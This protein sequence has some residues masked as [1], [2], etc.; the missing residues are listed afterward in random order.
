MLLFFTFCVPLVLA[1]ARPHEESKSEQ[2]VWHPSQGDENF[3]VAQ[4]PNPDDTEKPKSLELAW[5]YNADEV[6]ALFRTMENIYGSETVLNSIR[7]MLTTKNHD[8]WLLFGLSRTSTFGGNDM[9]LLKHSCPSDTEYNE[10]LVGLNKDKFN[11]TVLDM[12][13]QACSNF[14]FVPVTVSGLGNPPGDLKPSKQ[15]PV[16]LNDK[17]TDTVTITRSKLKNIPH[18]QHLEDIWYEN[19]PVFR[20]DPRSQQENML[21]MLP[22]MAPSKRPDVIRKTQLMRKINPENCD[23]VRLDSPTVYVQWAFLVEDLNI[24]ASQFGNAFPADNLRMEADE[25]TLEVAKSAVLDFGVKPIHFIDHFD[26]DN[27]TTNYDP[28]NATGHDTT[29]ENSTVTQ[30]GN[31]YT[32]SEWTEIRNVGKKASSFVKKGCSVLDLGQQFTSGS[33]FV[34]RIQMIETDRKNKR[35]FTSHYDVVKFYTCGTNIDGKQIPD[36]GECVDHV[37]AECTKLVYIWHPGSLMMNLP[38]STGIKIP[39]RLLGRLYLNLT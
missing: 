26:F 35:A 6:K 18:S 31:I 23:Y 28:F 27:S 33:L 17:A 14:T 38:P 1:I 32:P 24:N 21:R 13:D 7:F 2:V 19:P 4:I 12:M 30:S 10:M 5:S 3:P 11:D 37:V 9:V 39:V 16:T 22:G 34:N 20:I 15:R 8:G 29:V 25:F 36:I